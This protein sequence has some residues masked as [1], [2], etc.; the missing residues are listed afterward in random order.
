MIRCQWY[1]DSEPITA[2]A[3]GTFILSRSGTLRA[4]L[5]HKNG[6]REVIEKEITV[7]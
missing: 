5:T 7:R 6:S 3:D 1:Y 2:D 4:V